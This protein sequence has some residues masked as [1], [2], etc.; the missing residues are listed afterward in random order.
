MVNSYLSVRNL[1]V[2]YGSFVALQDVCIDIEEGEFVCFLGPSGCGK[3]TLLRAIAGLTPQADGQIWQAGQD[4]SRL[5]VGQRDFG[6]VFQSYALFPNMTVAGNVGYS[7]AADRSLSRAERFSRVRELLELVGLPDSAER[8]PAQLSG[9]Q[10]QR[11]AIARAFAAE[12][13]LIL[14]DEVTSALDVSVQAHV[15]GL[16]EA[17]QQK[18][19]A[20]CLFISHDLGVIKR[21]ANRTVVLEKGAVVEAGPTQDLFARPRHRYTQ[22]LLRAAL[23][24]DGG[25]A[26]LSLEPRRA[27]GLQGY[28]Q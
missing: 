10:Q 22:L 7:L 26:P 23:R 14:C 27:A 6:I 3:T 24:H 9:G 17:M 16:L 13:D 15:L 12:P 19:G 20:A 5:A 4:I 8:Y 18:T 2:R 11:V 1:S 25:G 21:V 28:S